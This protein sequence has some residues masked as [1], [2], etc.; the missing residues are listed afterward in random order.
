MQRTRLIGALAAVCA[1]AGAGSAQAAT[2]TDVITESDVARQAENTPPT[3]DWVVYKRITG[4]ANGAAAF[5]DG[6]GTPP[7]RT[8]SLNLRTPGTQDKTFVYNYEHAGEHVADLDEIAYSTWRTTGTGNQMPGI[9]IEIDKNGGTLERGDY[10]VLVFEPIYNLNQGAIT[11][12]A[13]KTW[14]GDAGK[15]W[16]NNT[17][18]PGQCVSAETACQRAWSFVR[19]N[20]PD[21]TIISIGVN[22]G[23][24]NATLNSD[25]D[26]LTL[27]TAS[28]EDTTVFDFEADDDTDGVG[29][30]Y[31]NCR[32]TA[33]PGQADAD[34]DGIGDACD[35]DRDGDGV[36]NGD[37]NCADTANAGQEDNESDGQ[38]DACDADDDNDS[39][40]DGDDNCATTPNADQIDHDG[41]GIGTAC[42]PVERPTSAEQCKNGG[43][44]DWTP[45]F[46]NQGEC[47]SFVA[48]SKKS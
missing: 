21:A 42:D 6:P 18:L 11:N 13:W 31:D 8:G 17:A 37:D 43:W 35:P 45:A 36:A 1:L 29:N 4:T 20:N 16:V 2:V 5:V 28:D 27:G 26:A 30:G 24:G 32:T 39:V 10:G 3:K 34:H 23:S 9:N 44:K 46:K 15:W 48:K 33:N 38:G 19:A 22:Q 40:D 12:N 7:G 47:V 25:V 14:D 41:D